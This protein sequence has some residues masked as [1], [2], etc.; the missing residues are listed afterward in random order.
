MLRADRLEQDLIDEQAASR[1]TRRGFWLGKGSLAILDQGLISSS[2]F[3]ISILLAR[4][5]FPEQYGAYALT[6]EIFSLLSLSYQA[7]ILEPM[8]VFG[9]SVYRNQLGQYLGMLLWVHLAL[10]SMIMVALGASAGVVREVASTRGLAQA[11]AGVALAAPSVLLLRL[12]RQ[13][14]YVKLAPR[15]AVLGAVVYSAVVLGGLFVVYQ[16]HLLSPFVAFLLMG[17]GALV[18]CPVLLS[19]LK[20]TLEKTPRFQSLREIGRRHWVYGRWALASSVLISS[21]WMI[22]Y[23]ALSLF[24]GMAASASLRALLNLYLPITQAL[25]AFSL[26]SLPY[27]AR[28]YQ[29]NG[30]ARV[31][32]LAWRLQA[33]YGGG[34]LAYWTVLILLRKPIVSFLYAGRYDGV[35]DLLPWLALG[36]VLWAAGMAQAIS[37][38]AIQSPASVFAAYATCGAVAL[39][40]GVPATWIFGLQ[41]AVCTVVCSSATAVG[42][43]FILLRRR[44]R[45][46]S[47]TFALVAKARPTLGGLAATQP[48]PATGA[49]DTDG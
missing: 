18:T 48:E 24:S 17:L 34:A 43:G 44:T 29:R 5:L 16:R 26:L 30:L 35:A 41:G 38:R 14:F 42:A 4:W 23:T 45:A 33:L 10:S 36:S 11:L 32:Q 49:W 6:F 40:A 27:A 12:V 8:S 15:E 21:P 31:E 19:R 7:L 28:V 9:P 13:A 47:G 25:T 1:R 39:V 46:V 37:L 3:L 22:Q 20:P 2:N